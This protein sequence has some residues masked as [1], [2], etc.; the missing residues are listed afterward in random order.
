[1][2][3]VKHWLQDR[4]TGSKKTN[5]RWLDLAEALE[6]FWD[7]QYLPLAERV[8]SC[9]SVFTASDEDLERRL[10]DLGDFFDVNLPASEGSRPLAIV[11]RRDEIRRKNTAVPMESILRRN[12]EGLEAQWEPLWAPV[13]GPYTPESMRRQREIE[14]PDAYY[15]TS[16]G[17]IVVNET[18]L[19]R[20]GI[21]RAAFSRVAVNEVDKVRPAHIVYD[22]ELFILTINFDYPGL[23]LA[24]NTQLSCRRQDYQLKEAVHGVLH[25]TARRAVSMGSLSLAGQ[26]WT[27]DLNSALSGSGL[28]TPLPGIEGDPLPPIGMHKRQTRMFQA[29]FSAA[30]ASQHCNQ[31]KARRHDHQFQQGAHGAI[32]QPGGR[33]V[34]LGS[35]S[36]SDQWWTLDL[37][38]AYTDSGGEKSRVSIPGIEGDA[39]PPIGV[40]KRQERRFWAPFSAA[41]ASE[42]DGL[43]KTRLHALQERPCT[44]TAQHPKRRPETTELQP[45]S[46]YSSRAMRQFDEVPADFC[47]LDTP[48]PNHDAWHRGASSSAPGKNNNQQEAH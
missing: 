4:L 6:G 22:G 26:L 7:Q 40:H 29:P 39:L 32:P 8:E 31:T 23:S 17:L 28:S 19:R 11:F 44:L 10:E 21:E 27:L 3:V 41:M 15:M 46:S 33:A 9:R 1:M 42:T 45:Q 16:R 48:I 12:F 14:D 2:I 36:L 25:K 13:A 18:Q 43:H 35:L 5:R 47:P 38:A 20:M 24:V 30:M 34:A 37:T